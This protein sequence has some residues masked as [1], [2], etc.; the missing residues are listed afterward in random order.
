MWKLVKPYCSHITI[1]ISFFQVLVLTVT[2]SNVKRRRCEGISAHGLCVC[3]MTFNQQ[4]HLPE[5]NMFPCQSVLHI[6]FIRCQ[7]TEVIIDLQ[8]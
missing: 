8:G 6:F 1:N 4:P 2:H 5:R 7:H 3:K